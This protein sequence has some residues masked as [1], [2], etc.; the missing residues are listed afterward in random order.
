MNLIIN[1]LVSAITLLVIQFFA[2]NKHYRT[3]S[4]LEDP[5]V[6]ELFGQLKHRGLLADSLIIQTGLV[7]LKAKFSIGHDQ[8]A[9][10][11]KSIKNFG[12]SKDY[13][14]NVLA[15]EYAKQDHARLTYMLK[16]KQQVKLVENYRFGRS[17]SRVMVS[18]LI[19]LLV[20]NCAHKIV[21]Q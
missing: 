13:S 20:L 9:F 7:F 2:L 18:V 11:K 3:I 14:L 12:Y 19:I 17:L 15:L 1:S 6:I 4:L 8:E 5:Q 10:I 16:N 21:V